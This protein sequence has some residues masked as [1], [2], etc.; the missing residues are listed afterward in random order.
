MV[1]IPS[2]PDTQVEGDTKLKAEGPQPREGPLWAFKNNYTG[3]P[4]ALLQ[5]LG[6]ARHQRIGN[7]KLGTQQASSKKTIT[8]RKLH[9]ILPPTSL[10]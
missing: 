1:V 2:A 3:C 5:V 4:L 6:V 7:P 9:N 8:I 10:A